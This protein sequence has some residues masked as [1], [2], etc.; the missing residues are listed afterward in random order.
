MKEEG[1]RAFR[2]ASKESCTKEE[3][4]SNR[5]HRDREAEAVRSGVWLM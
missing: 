4:R 2:G 3:Y 5:D 1:H